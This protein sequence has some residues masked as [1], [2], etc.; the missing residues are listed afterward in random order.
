[1]DIDLTTMNESRNHI[2]TGYT[3]HP[4]LLQ[5]LAQSQSQDAWREFD[6]RYGELVLSYCRSRGLQPSDAEDIR[7]ITM[8][9]MA[10]VLPSF[11]YDPVRGR[12]RAY[13]RRVVQ[14]AIIRHLRPDRPGV[15]SLNFDSS[16]THLA[17]DDGPFDEIWEQAWIRHHYRLAM[18]TLR[19]TCD[20]KTL[21]VFD[22][23]VAGE[24]VNAVSQ[25]FGMTEETVRRTRLRVKNKLKKLI[26]T[27]IC[28]EDELSAPK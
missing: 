5:R 15:L 18:R 27:Q 7:Q 19:N 12:F 21:A 1:M 6:S 23:F 14:S 20:S 10:K 17:K 11:K 16:T 28:E 3:T 25:M 4:S 26:E 2:M 9:S 22:R 24:S 8:I 13:L